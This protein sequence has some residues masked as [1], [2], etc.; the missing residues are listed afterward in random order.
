[1]KR[2]AR[3]MLTDDAA[4][5]RITSGFHTNH[6]TVLSTT[7]APATDRDLGFQMRMLLFQ[8]DEFAK[9]A[10]LDVELLVEDKYPPGDVTHADE[11]VNDVRAHI[12]GNIVDTV[13]AHIWTVDS[14]VAKITD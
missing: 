6:R 14:P 8:C 1:M 2:H 7:F 12:S 4:D 11:G 5:Q 13:A 9:A 3:I 10:F